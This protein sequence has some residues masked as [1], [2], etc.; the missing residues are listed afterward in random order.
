M[1]LTAA[2][3]LPGGATFTVSG[4]TTGWAPA[5]VTVTVAE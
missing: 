1:L 4:S 5:T 2:S 3:M